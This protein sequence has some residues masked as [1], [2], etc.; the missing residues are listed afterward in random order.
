[1][2]RWVNL[3][4]EAGSFPRILSITDEDI[5]SGIKLLQLISVLSDKPIPRHKT[6][7]L[8][9]AQKLDNVDQVLKL[10][11]IA[12]I[13]TDLF[14]NE[15]IVN[16]N[17]KMVFDLLW[18]IFEQFSLSKISKK[19]NIGNVA[20]SDVLRGRSALLQWVQNSTSKPFATKNNV[21]NFT[22]DWSDGKALCSVLYHHGARQLEARAMAQAHPRQRIQIAL[23][24]AQE[25][26]KVPRLIEV[27]DVMYPEEY[28]IL[29]YVTELNFRV[30]E[31]KSMAR[32]GLD[33]KAQK[34]SKS[35]MTEEKTMQMDGQKSKIDEL[36]E[37]KAIVKQEA[38]A[39]VLREN[40]LQ[41]S[42]S[43]TENLQRIFLETKKDLLNVRAREALLGEENRNLKARLLE[44]TQAQIQSKNVKLEGE[45]KSCTS[46]LGRSEEVLKACEKEKKAL[47]ERL[48]RETE[49]R[50]K[51]ENSLRRLVKA[52]SGQNE[53]HE[54]E[55]QSLQ[56]EVSAARCELES[57]RKHR[58][59]REKE[60]KAMRDRFRAE[61]KRKEALEKKVAKLTL[62]SSVDGKHDDNSKRL[63]FLE[64]AN[65]L[66]ETQ[67][68]DLHVR[69]SHMSKELKKALHAQLKSLT[70]LRGP[71]R[72]SRRT[73]SGAQS[74]TSSQ[75]S[76]R[77]LASTFS[78]SRHASAAAE[79]DIEIQRK[80]IE[81]KLEE[82]IES[83]PHGNLLS[84]IKDNAFMFGTKRIH[85][86]I[87]TGE[88]HVRVGGGYASLKEF[89]NKYGNIERIH[90][91]RKNA[92]VNTTQSKGA[93]CE[94]K[95]PH[96]VRRSRKCQL[97][98]F[99]SP[100]QP[101]S[102]A[103]VGSTSIGNKK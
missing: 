81:D 100:S 48:V 91:R 20:G 87:L 39:K 12:G 53:R 56:K 101:R 25:I 75:A 73:R 50:Q 7:R 72:N 33:E 26:F 23:K 38:K 85:L 102:R 67:I 5:K 103:V 80:L 13:S 59:A 93:R 92:K 65:R 16:G 54:K 46:C 51:L 96:S 55:L 6:K 60:A 17:E 89:C 69:I 68:K 37:L 63:V 34:E 58:N 43:A 61:R 62:G 9:R 95:S 18:A 84:H 8:D 4:L 40:A 94:S 14:Q 10:L 36:Q 90:M 74:R 31:T 19:P 29:L 22:T 30:N 64:K 77:S 86:Y 79:D 11:E 82:F 66:K 70:L 35:R 2:I 98:A 3:Q 41:E 57:E 21:S 32:K 88:L 49:E 45:M 52:G 47:M 78:S 97:K 15:Q 27:A 99:E 44:T 71:T 28:S 42:R 1:M 24:V 76:S 83:N